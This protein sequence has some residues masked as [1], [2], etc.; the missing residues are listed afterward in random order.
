[1][2][3]RLLLL[4]PLLVSTT[5]CVAGDDSN[6]TSKIN[7]SVHV[8]AGQAPSDAS[9]VNGSIE[10]AANARVEDASTV[11]GSISLGDHAAA[12]SADTVNGG[13]SLDDGAQVSGN[14]ES[15][16]GALKLSPG[17]AVGG[18]ATNVNGHI[19]IDGAHVGGQV[20]TVDGDIDITGNARVDGG[21]L[22]HKP[23]SGWFHFGIDRDPVVTIGPGATVNGTLKFE[24]P[25]K[26]YVSDRATVGQIVG[27]TPVKFS[28]DQPPA[29]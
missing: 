15:V 16:N 6:G 24:R 11:N 23:D 7:G 4:L 3:L 1:M 26:L 19:T 12:K 2:K 14:I 20:E 22:V 9:S 8:E 28:G 21:L 25:V 29:N 5:A 18:H 17:A 27:A 10:V 13:V